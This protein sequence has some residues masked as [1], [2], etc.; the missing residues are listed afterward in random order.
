MVPFWD[1]WSKTTT[2]NM[3]LGNRF[4]MLV[5]SDFLCDGTKIVPFWDNWSEITTTNTGLGNRFKILVGS[6]FS[7]DSESGVTRFPTQ[8]DRG[9][10]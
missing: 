5:R 8:I 9:P 7:C 4:K 6:E 10:I 2:T 1:N 3:R